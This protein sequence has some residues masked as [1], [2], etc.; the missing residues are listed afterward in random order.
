MPRAD[1]AFAAR[2]RDP[3]RAAVRVPRRRAA[4]RAPHARGD[5]PPLARRR[6]GGG[7]GSTR[8]RRD[9]ARPRG[10]V[11]RPRKAPTSCTTRCW[12]LRFVTERGGRASRAMARV[13][14]DADRV[15]ASDEARARRRH[16]N[17]PQ[18]KARCGSPPERL[19]QF[20][21]VFPH[22]RLSPPI[23]A[24]EEFAAQSWSCDEALVEIV[25][26]R[27]QG[28]GPVTAAALGRLDGAAGADDRDGAH[29]SSRRKASR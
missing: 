13:P 28:L 26:G 16:R 7:S 10:S 23:A 29:R 18:P 15:E 8:S 24:P 21:A 12:G 17:P 6:I 19:P 27:L 9:R 20:A 1:G 2:A 14:R 3:R 25:R 5:G 11:A 22:A 4:G